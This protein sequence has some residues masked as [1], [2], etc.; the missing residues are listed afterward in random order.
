MDP[1]L[2]TTHTC[3]CGDPWCKFGMEELKVENEKQEDILMKINDV[4][5]GEV[6]ERTFEKLPEEIEELKLFNEWGKTATLKWND[7]LALN[8]KL[9]EEIEKLKE[10]KTVLRRNYAKL[11]YKT[12]RPVTEDQVIDYSSEESVSDSEEEIEYV[13]P[14]TVAEL[15]DSLVYRNRNSDTLP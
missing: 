8:K 10:E 1:K 3:S 5:F 2:S 4:V 6:Y 13:G 9:K 14:L 15:S 7:E 12:H 11:H